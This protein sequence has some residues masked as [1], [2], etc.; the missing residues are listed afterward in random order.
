MK[1]GIMQ[2]YFLPYIGYFQLIRSVDMFIIYDNIKY[3]KKGWINRNRFLL[4]GTSG[5]FSLSL[6]NGSD[7]LN[8][9]DRELAADFD[10]I[11]LLNR[12]KNAYMRAPYFKEVFPFLE[13]IILNPNN[14]LFNY[15]YISVVLLCE[16]LGIDTKILI[17]SKIPIDHASKGQDKILAMCQSLN[18]SIYINPIGGSELYSKEIFA[19]HG[20]ALKFIK[21]LPFSYPQHGNDFV[22][23]L[24]IIDVMMFNS[25][26]YI[27]QQL[28]K[29]YELVY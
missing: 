1:L 11:K 14:N 19:N 4:N 13:R 15:I 16:R 21:S 24:S 5:T 7:N 28:L 18:A 10:R 27:N 17:S 20:L 22:S 6:K 12:F 3:T 26:H 8:I 2:P 9:I 29:K 23:W 25:T